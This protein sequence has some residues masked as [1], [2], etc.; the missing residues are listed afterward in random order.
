[1]SS[2][3][4]ASADAVNPD[5]ALLRRRR[6]RRRAAALAALIGLLVWPGLLDSELQK[7][8]DTLRVLGP[9]GGH[10]AGAAGGVA[11]KTLGHA[12]PRLARAP[13]PPN[14]GALRE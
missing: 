13:L 9:V 11:G 12:R 6:R 2:E 3:P 1:M 4:P 14:F 5:V 10:G 8:L 7:R